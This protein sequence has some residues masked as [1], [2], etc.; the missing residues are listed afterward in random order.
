[1]KTHRAC[2]DVIYELVAFYHWCYCCC[3]YRIFSLVRMADCDG[4]VIVVVIMAVVVA[5][6][7]VVTGVESIYQVH[8]AQVNCL[9]GTVSLIIT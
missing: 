2:Y 5:G 7:V 9:V 1:M 8:L 3:Y 6:G 4:V